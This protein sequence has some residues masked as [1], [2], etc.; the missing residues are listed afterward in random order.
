MQ[1]IQ[2]EDALVFQMQ[3]R[4]TKEQM[5]KLKHSK[6]N[7]NSRAEQIILKLRT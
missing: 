2:K 5:A 4:E 7:A 3:E 1:A 6:E